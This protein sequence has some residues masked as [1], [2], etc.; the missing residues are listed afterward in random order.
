MN[1]LIVSERYDSDMIF[2]Y[3]VVNDRREEMTIKINKNDYVIQGSELFI[4][5]GT[6]FDVVHI[7]REN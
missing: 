7:N 3:L 6:G 2:D 1:N 4:K 5:I